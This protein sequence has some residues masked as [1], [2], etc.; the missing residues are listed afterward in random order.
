M[1]RIGRICSPMNTNAST[2]SRKTTV[3]QTAYEG[4]RIRAGVR[5]GAVRATVIA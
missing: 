1:S 5:S 3:A 2:L 4:M